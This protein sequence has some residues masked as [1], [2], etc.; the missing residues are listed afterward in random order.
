MMGRWETVASFLALL[1]LASMGLQI[2]WHRLKC[3]PKDV[4]P[5]VRFY[6][7]LAVIMLGLLWLGMLGLLV[8]A[9]LSRWEAVVRSR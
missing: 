3:L 2:A 1:L 8:Q 7:G 9:L 5:A 6:W 4:L